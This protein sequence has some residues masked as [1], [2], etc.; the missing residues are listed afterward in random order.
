MPTVHRPTRK[1]TDVEILRDNS[2]GI[3]LA[4]IAKKH[5]CHPTGI[6]IRLKALNV[7]PTDT[8]RAFMEDVVMGLPLEVREWLA[9]LMMDGGN[10]KDFVRDMLQYIYELDQGNKNE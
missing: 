10:I 1:A 2:I 4:T 8:R 3:S 5:G 7:P 9:D 6:T